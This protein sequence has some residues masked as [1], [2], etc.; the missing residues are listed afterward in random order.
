[1]TKFQNVPYFEHSENIRIGQTFAVT[2]LN[3]DDGTSPTY[4]DLLR[5][6]GLSYVNGAA[7]HVFYHVGVV[8][9]SRMP[10]DYPQVIPASVDAIWLSDEKY[11]LTLLHSYKDRIERL[12][13]MAG[14]TGLFSHAEHVEALHHAL[15]G[16]LRHVLD[17]KSPPKPGYNPNMTEWWDDMIEGL[18]T[19]SSANLDRAGLG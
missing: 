1:M 18:G 6:G 3:N 14:N 13:G 7:E 5:Y 2:C 11:R 15:E 10:C 19:E 4:L 9:K 8:L 12:H 17:L 16:T